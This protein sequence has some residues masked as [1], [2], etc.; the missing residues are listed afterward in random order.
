MEMYII[1]FTHHD[2]FEGIP[3]MARK[4]DEAAR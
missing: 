3:F 2:K 4:A 1:I